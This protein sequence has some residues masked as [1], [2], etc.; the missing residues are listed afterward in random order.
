MGINCE[1]ERGGEG[2]TLIALVSWRQRGQGERKRKQAM[3]IH[4][5]QEVWSR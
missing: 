5:D 1:S 4:V 2:T 3:L